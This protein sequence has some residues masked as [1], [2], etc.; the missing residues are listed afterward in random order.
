[1]K[2]DSPFL[3]LEDGPRVPV[4][5]DG[6]PLDLP[7]GGN[8]AAALLAAGVQSFRRTPV[9]G[10]PRGPFCMMGACFDCLVEIDGVQRQACMVEVS[11]GLEVARAGTGDAP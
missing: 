4:R 8:L 7:E 9:S 1:V 11:R 2:T 6:E 10:A 3:E 5:F